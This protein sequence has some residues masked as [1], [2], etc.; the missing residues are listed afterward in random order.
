MGAKPVLDDVSFTIHRG[1]I[2]GVAGI[3]GNGQTELIAAL[4]GMHPLTAGTVRM[5]DDDITAWS[6]R[7]RREAG[8]GYV[9]EDRER[10]AVGAGGQRVGRQDLAELA[11]DA[12][13]QDEEGD[14][15]LLLDLDEHIRQIGELDGRCV[16]DHVLMA[17]LRC[18][19][20]Q[21]LGRHLFHQD[22]PVPGSVADPQQRRRQR[23]CR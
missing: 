11:A 6:T 9:P 23:T 10:R 19:V 3:E 8:M 12:V 21:Y 7:H 16:G 18:Q 20:V 5:G 2:V 4:L 17:P 13:R 15:P 22:A 1:E 14:A